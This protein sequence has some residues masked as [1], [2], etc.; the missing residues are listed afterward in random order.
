VTLGSI[1]GAIG[2]Q[3]PLLTFYNQRILKKEDYVAPSLITDKEAEDDK[4]PVGSTQIAI[5]IDENLLKSL[6]NDVLLRQLRAKKNE[7]IKHYGIKLP[8]IGKMHS[9]KLKENFFIIELDGIPVAEGELKPGSVLVRCDH[10]LLDVSNIPYELAPPMGNIEKQFWVA[11]A[12]SSKLDGAG[13]KYLTLNETII[14]VVSECFRRNLGAFLGLQEVQDW[15][16]DAGRTYPD[17]VNEIRQMIQPQKLMDVFKRLLGDGIS[18]AGR[19]PLLEALLNWAAREEDPAMLAE[20]IRVTLRRRICFTYAN[21]NKV[22]VAAIFDPSLED[23]VRKSIR[24]TNMGDF[25]A[26]DDPTTQGL[27]AH[28]KQLNSEPRF[29]SPTPIIL[30]SIDLRRFV[31]G[32]LIKHGIDLPVLSHQDIA[33]DFTV[34]VIYAIK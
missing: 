15:L 8:P 5:F 13:L 29:M 3:A 17:M 2:F 27:L 24:R 6:N 34:Q 14:D 18:L 7:F 16:T 11:E 9:A 22:M 26:L 4:A 23:I 1:F 28:I 21:E 33:E 12:D 30:C 20:L 32:F 25:L 19:R 10:T 31:R